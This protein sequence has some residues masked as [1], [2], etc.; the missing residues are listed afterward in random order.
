MNGFLSYPESSIH[1]LALVG[2]TVSPPTRNING[3]IRKFSGGLLHPIK[4]TGDPISHSDEVSIRVVALAIVWGSRLPMWL[5]LWSEQFSSCCISN[6]WWLAGMNLLLLAACP[7]QSPCEVHWSRNT[8]QRPCW[9]SGEASEACRSSS[10]FKQVF[11]WGRI[12]WI[13]STQKLS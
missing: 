8:K 9:G 6:N 2:V 3:N 10:V 12:F 1:F 13:R 4:Y 11:F 5:S 7:L